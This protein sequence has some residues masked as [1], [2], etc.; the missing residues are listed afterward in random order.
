MET[1]DPERA[2]FTTHL[3]YYVRRRF[4]EVMGNRGAKKRPEIYAIS[5]DEPFDGD[6][7][8]TRADMLT[9]PRAVEA[10]DNLVESVHNT[11]LHAALDT[12]LATV[13]KDH[14]DILRARYYQGKTLKALAA[15]SG[16]AVANIRQQE[17]KALQSMRTG[18]NASRLKEYREHITSRSYRHSSFSAF[19][20]AGGSSV[21]WA[22]EKLEDWR[23]YW[24]QETSE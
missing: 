17:S 7:A 21:E 18:K 22:V 5:L 3:S 11:Q 9:D 12:C 1:F 19:Q 16:K 23:E 10:F 15:E 6:T 4:S 13:E 20:S 24:L 8:G 2:E 14:A